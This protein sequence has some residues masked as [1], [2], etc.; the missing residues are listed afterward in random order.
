[1]QVPAPQ[2]KIVE[3][4]SQYASLEEVK[5]IFFENYLQHQNTDNFNGLYLSMKWKYGKMIY[6]I[7]LMPLFIILTLLLYLI[8]TISLRNYIT[9]GFSLL[10]SILANYMI[11]NYYMV[12]RMRKG[13][14]GYGHYMLKSFTSIEEKYTINGGNFWLAMLENQGIEKAELI[15]HSGLVKTEESGEIIGFVEA[16]GICAKYRG[17]GVGKRLIEKAIE[18]GLENKFDRLQ[19][20]VSA[21]NLAGVNLYKKYG[22]EIVKTVE[23]E[24]ITGISYHVMV[25]PLKPLIEQN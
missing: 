23:V 8:P 16:F 3:Y 18:F 11:F 15:G 10:V 13:H 12:K 7:M 9:C 6:L 20:Y 25:K 2:L 24:K 1:M 14:V 22:F 21:V 17:I 4:D 5:K 19:L